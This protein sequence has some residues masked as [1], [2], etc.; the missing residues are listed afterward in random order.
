MPN[1]TR[2]IMVASAIA[3][4]LLA[5]GYASAQ[6]VELTY[7]GS[8]G[9]LAQVMDGVFDKPFEEE[10]GIAINALAT[11]DRTS[12]MKAMMQAGDP[13]WDVAELTPVDYANASLNGWL[14][15]IN[16]EEV[17]PEGRL[18][19]DAKLEDA[20]IAA[21][22][23]TVLAQRTDELPEGKKMTSWADFWDVETFPG[24]RALEDSVLDNLEF[25]LIADGVS[26]DEV[27]DV[28]STDE[29]VDRAFAK[30]DE[31]KPH[32]VSW[33]SAGAQPVQMLSDGEVYYT[34]AWNGRITQ[35]QDEDVP[36][37]I[38]WDGAGLKP[39]YVGILKGTEHK[40]AAQKY[41]SFMLTDPERSAEF[42]QTVSYPGMV[43]G[44][45]DHMPEDTGKKLPTHPDNIDGQFVT[46]AKFWAQNMDRLQ[47]RWEEWLLE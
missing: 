27:Y 17:D 19:D 35:L 21:T 26:P 25:A 40:E 41:I 46:D 31:I 47:E 1:L 23:S 45:Y 5:V 4:P 24:P 10:T 15:P 8:G 20:G 39:S 22:Y 13:I 6:D 12:A 38:V 2:R 33:W 7:A 29:G 34:S 32:I 11:T 36:V 9:G 18:P 30:L 44:L 37:E 16:W 43:N 14:E 42:A 3:V 28:L